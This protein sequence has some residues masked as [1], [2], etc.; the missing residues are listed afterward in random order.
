[1]IR[2]VLI[3]FL[4]PFT[5]YSQTNRG[6]FGFYDKHDR[7]QFFAICELQTLSGIAHGLEQTVTY[8]YSHFKADY[9][10]INDNF[11][12][13][14]ISWKNKYKDNDPSKGAKFFGSTSL[15]V[16]TTD[17]KHLMDFCTDVPNY[18]CIAL[19]LFVNHGRLKWYQIVSRALV[20]T[21]VREIGFNV[22][23]KIYQ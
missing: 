13:P 23:Y 11:F 9:P 3:L 18:I 14:A 15:L 5:L 2:L 16:F 17:F 21:A 4:L 10:N 7:R 20:A 19:P 12:N 6:V 1:M 22:V 8:H